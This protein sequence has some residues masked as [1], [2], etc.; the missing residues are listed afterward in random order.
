MA[1]RSFVK[2][3]LMVSNFSVFSGSSEAKRRFLPGQADI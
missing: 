2:K 3:R 1:G